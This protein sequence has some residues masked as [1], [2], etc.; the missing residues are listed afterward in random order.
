MHTQLDICRLQK[1]RV[2]RLGDKFDEAK[3]DSLPEQEKQKLWFKGGTVLD[4]VCLTVICAY[5]S[6]HTLATPH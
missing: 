4:Q 3:L 1:P 2:C 6:M 5:M